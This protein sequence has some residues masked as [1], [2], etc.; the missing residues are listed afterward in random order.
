MRASIASLFL[1]LLLPTLAWAQAPLDPESAPSECRDR[2]AGSSNSYGVDTECVA[3]PSNINPWQKQ[4]V[5]S[6][7]SHLGV[8]LV[9][10][11]RYPF[12]CDW[13][14]PEQAHRLLECRRDR[15]SPLAG[16]TF[17][18]SPVGETKCEQKY[19]SK[20]GCTDRTPKLMVLQLSTCKP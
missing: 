6:E 20:T 10:A 13:E 5:L 2:W 11:A 3:R 16:A 9:E 17:E 8:G 14:S 1:L 7:L 18:R 4:L 12:R 19:V 15:L